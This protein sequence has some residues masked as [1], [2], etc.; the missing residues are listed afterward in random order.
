MLKRMY[1]LKVHGEIKGHATAVHQ[2]KAKV[3]KGHV[4]VNGH[5]SLRLVYMLRRRLEFMSMFL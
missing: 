5:V 4:I 3:K 2:V 1:F